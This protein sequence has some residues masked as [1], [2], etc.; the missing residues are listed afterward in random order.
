ME[1]NK[2]CPGTESENAGKAAGCEGCPGQ[3]YCST[4][5]PLPV[6]PDLALIADNLKNVKNILVVLSTVVYSCMS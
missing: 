1:V 6:D 5:Q 4:G 3:K 2:S